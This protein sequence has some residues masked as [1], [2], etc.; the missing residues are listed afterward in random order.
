MTGS[1]ENFVHRM[2]DDLISGALHKIAALYA[3]P[4]AVYFGDDVIILSDEAE[5]LAALGAYRSI[6]L[7][8]GVVRIEP[9]SINAPDVREDRFKTTLVNAYLGSCG[10][11]IASSRVRFYLSRKEKM[12]KIR[13]VEYF[14]WPFPDDVASCHALHMSQRGAVNSNICSVGPA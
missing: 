7:R 6:L 2:T 4:V 11:K 13:M 3:F 14:E 10:R 12:A 5:F 9:E 8:R 1:I